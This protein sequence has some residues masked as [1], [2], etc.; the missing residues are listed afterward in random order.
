MSADYVNLMVTMFLGGIW[1]GAGWTFVIWGTLHGFYLVINHLWRGM[2]R[3]I[4]FDAG[5]PSLW[6]V[7]GGRLLTFVAVVV[8]WVIF[9]AETMDG[10]W[11]LISS[12][13]AL[14][15]LVLPVEFMQFVVPGLE[16]EF[17]K[18][19]VLDDE[20]WLW[21]LVLFLIVMFAPNTQQIMMRY[22][23]G[24]DVDKHIVPYRFSFVEWR[25]G[26]VSAVIIFLMFCVAQ[27][28][29]DGPSEFLYFDF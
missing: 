21:L 17:I 3:I 13:F 29:M 2:L 22:K 26:I 16:V 25:P 20:L 1:H 10:A 23:P 4:G 19:R 7:I 15:G 14:N 5:K 24:Y 8:A 18:E 12:M 27:Y 9:R 28:R 11:H 6:G